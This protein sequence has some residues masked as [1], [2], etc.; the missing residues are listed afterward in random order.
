MISK[1]LF[2]ILPFNNY[3]CSNPHSP[4]MFQESICD[5]DIGLTLFLFTR[6][7]VSRVKNVFHGFSI[8]SYPPSIS[9]FFHYLSVP[10][11][12]NMHTTP[13][14]W[15]VLIKT[16]LVFLFYFLFFPPPV[17]IHRPKLLIFILHDKYV[18]IIC[19]CHSVTRSYF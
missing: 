8:F 18:F 16:R 5:N 10:R 7:C 6:N 3:P 14:P 4:I 13:S 15:Y 17:C 2:M 9:F 1:I 12:L 19:Q 11:F